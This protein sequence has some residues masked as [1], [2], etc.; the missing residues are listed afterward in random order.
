MKLSSDM[1]IVYSYLH[2][3]DLYVL[4]YHTASINN[5]KWGQIN[6]ELH[7]TCEH[8]INQYSMPNYTV[9]YPVNQYPRKNNAS[10]LCYL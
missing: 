8:L 10:F 3:H 1:K 6:H 2:L 5:K 9:V 7:F 4:K